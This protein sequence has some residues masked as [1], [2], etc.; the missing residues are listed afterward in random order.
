MLESKYRL[1]QLINTYN[2]SNTTGTP[3][4]ETV[5]RQELKCLIFSDDT[6][7]QFSE[8]IQSTIMPRTKHGSE[9]NS[10]VDKSRNLEQHRKRRVST[11]EAETDDTWLCATISVPTLLRRYVSSFFSSPNSF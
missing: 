8:F 9:E 10:P 2:F 6:R 7:T 4:P 3:A 1:T 5:T 11:Y